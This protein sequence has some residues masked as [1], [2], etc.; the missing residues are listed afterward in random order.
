VALLARSRDALENLTKECSKN[1]V[2]AQ[3]IIC[4]MASKQSVEDSCKKIG[5]IF[6]NRVDILINNAG[7]YGE[8]SS[9]MEEKTPTGKDTVDMWEEVM[10]VNLVNLMRMTGRCLPMM[11]ECK[12]AAVITISS[13][14]ATV[15]FDFDIVF[16]NR[17]LLLYILE[18][19]R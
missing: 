7:I 11:K 10:M 5:E 18:D 8:Q 14:A 6:E 15:R 13:V 16:V 9:A 1:G 3:Y 12:H 2:N 19:W 17:L 4:D